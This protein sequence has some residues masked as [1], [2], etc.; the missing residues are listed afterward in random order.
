MNQLT[1]LTSLVLVVCMGCGS[2]PPSQTP[3]VAPTAKPQPAE[4]EPEPAD[5]TDTSEPDTEANEVQ[6][7]MPPQ[8][9]IRPPC[10]TL[11]KSRCSISQ[12][13]KWYE[14]GSSG[15]CMDE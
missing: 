12:G 9:P 6:P 3:T 14:K 5:E 13:C 8:E 4:V 11:E 10:H 1:L 2:P 7:T 15:E